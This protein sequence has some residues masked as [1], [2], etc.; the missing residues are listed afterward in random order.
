MRKIMT[1]SAAMLCLSSAAAA[2]TA[3]TGEVTVTGCLMREAD[4]RK[5]H[6]EGRGGVL[7]SGVGV[8]DEFVLADATPSMNTERGRRGATRRGER[9]V[10]R[11]VG[12]G[13][14]PRAATR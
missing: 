11:P 10:G 3:P 5:L 12:T 1:C 2:Q 14:T 8:G 6:D 13:G 7:G 9:V 4:Y